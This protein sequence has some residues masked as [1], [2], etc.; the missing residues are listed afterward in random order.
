MGGLGSGRRFSH[1]GYVDANLAIDI[2][3]WKRKGILLS[4]S[5]FTWRWLV[6]DEEQAQIRVL[7]EDGHVV[8]S[9]RTRINFGEWHT[10]ELTVTLTYSPCNY[11][12]ERIWFSCPVCC[13]RAAKLFCHGKYFICRKC[14]GQLYESQ[15]EWG[16]HR[17][18]R[19][20]RRL[21][22]KLGVN[23]YRAV[24]YP[25]KPK[26]MHLKTYKY[27]SNEAEDNFMSIVIEEDKIID[28]LQLNLK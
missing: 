16:L 12:G 15:S 24:S 19:K 8:L 25:V 26:G 11:G 23:S 18:Y 20:G 14:T 4:G 1:R 9:Y 13:R 2:R 6:N 27:I 7:V 5:I 10:V 28:D 17:L 21:S 3:I 22:L